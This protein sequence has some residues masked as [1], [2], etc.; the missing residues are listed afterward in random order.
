MQI[1]LIVVPILLVVGLVLIYNGLVQMRLLTRNAWADVETMLQRRAELVPNLVETVKGFATY[2]QSTLDRV[3]QARNQAAE[4]SSIT[5]RAS[6]ER[7]VGAGVVS[8][9]ALAEAYPDLKAGQAFLKL[10]EELSQTEKLIANARQYYN[11]CVRDYNIRR[12]KFP[13]SLVAGPLGFAPA[14]F[15]ELD[16]PGQA[17]APSLKGLP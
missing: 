1:V 15:F 3:L 12:E 5:S 16:D 9:L 17:T 2:E 11:A 14:E 7:Q 6:A 4:A 8:I 10:Q 13:N